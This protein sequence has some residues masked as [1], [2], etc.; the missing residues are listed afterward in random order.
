MMRKIAYGGVGA[1]LVFAAGFYVQQH[2]PLRAGIESAL[3]GSI[4]PGTNVQ[5][6]SSNDASGTAT[7][8]SEDQE[9][10][11]TLSFVEGKWQNTI[12]VLNKKTGNIL[13]SLVLRDR[14][15][16]NVHGTSVN[17]CHFYVLSQS[18]YDESAQKELPG[19]KYGVW[20]RDYF[21]DDPGTMVLTEAENITGKENGT[22]EY[23]S[24]EFTVDPSEKYM[25]LI[26]GYMGQPDYSLI[27]KDITT[28]KDVYTLQLNDILKTHPNA[29][30][31]F[32]TG[33][34]I[35][36]PDG[37]YLVSPI[38]ETDKENALI[39]VKRGTWETSIYDTP[40]DYLHGVEGAYAPFE[41]YFAYADVPTWTGTEDGEQ[42]LN[43][44]AT[45]EG[46]TEK[47]LIVANLKTGATTTIATVPLKI[48][49]RFNPAWL[50]DTTLQ[51]TMPDGTKKT[52]KVPH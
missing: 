10:K 11:R 36:G 33:S 4:N 23:Y 28:G 37:M 8:L 38:D 18:N 52:Y 25:S 20:R 29:A 15:S 2:T 31:T 19:Y 30:G 41:P 5:A 42:I 40:T 50:D 35:Q 47:H 22:K 43:N 27:I 46:K 32:N 24:T 17:R 51:Y 12:S 14:A 26:H 49:Q 44:I 13:W 6:T 16:T 39:Y 45:K 3:S 7:C 34:W 21:S 1:L 48:G 9:E